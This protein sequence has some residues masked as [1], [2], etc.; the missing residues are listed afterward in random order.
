M[1]NNDQSCCAKIS[2]CS[3]GMSLAI[4][5]SLT[6]FFGAIL[7]AFFG[8][9][10]PFIDIFSTI[11]WGYDATIIGAFLGLFWAFIGGFIAGALIAFFYNFC[12]KNC[13]CKYCKSNHKCCE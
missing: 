4:V 11:Y 1:N 13:P 5:W 10:Y 12:Y 3:L 7:A 9:G 2:V 8:I 6:I